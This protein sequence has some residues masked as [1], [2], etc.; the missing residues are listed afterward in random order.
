MTALRVDA[1]TFSP[2]RDFRLGP[3]SFDVPSG[4]RVALVGPSGSGK[5]TLLRCL[6]GLE[7][8][9]AGRILFG[10]RIVFGGGVEVPP[11]ERGIGFVSQGGALWPHM[12]ALE[13]VR[14]AAPSRSKSDAV[15]L[16]SN[17]GLAGLECRRPDSLSGGEAQRL[18]LAR[19]LAPDPRVLLLDE[20]LS[21]VD[22]H[23]R[24]E[25]AL[26]VRALS[27]ER[28]LTVVVVTHDRDEALAMSDDLVVLR[29]GSLV[30]SGS[31]V[32][33]LSAPRTAFTAAFLGRAAC[34]ATRGEDGRLG[35]PFG[36]VARPVGDGPWSLV[37]LWG[38][39]VVDDAG[40]GPRACVLRCA[41]NGARFSVS[42]ELNG[43]TVRF[44]DR[45]RREAGES[46]ALKLRG[47]PRLLPA[48][49]ENESAAS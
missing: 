8:P 20:P 38:D 6:A 30:E 16:L 43:Q 10:D 15:A 4:S 14:F 49:T 23:L 18:A 17:V 42:A 46:V 25:L 28:G 36:E 22:V 11:S 9:A 45:V 19:A 26:L 48:S 34:L 41:P 39:A 12:T 29:D 2:G 13:H 33:L 27:A 40:E 35:T 3:L 31:A 32:E 1:L 21:S 7:R 5:T 24:D 47:E 44:E 37:L